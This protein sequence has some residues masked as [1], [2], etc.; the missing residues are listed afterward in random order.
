MLVRSDGATSG[1]LSMISTWWFVAIVPVCLALG[2][3]MV[4][5]FVS[6]QDRDLRRR[7]EFAERRANARVELAFHDAL[8][9]ACREAIR[10]E[11]SGYKA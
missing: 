11:S 4:A 2:G 7:A 5:V 3:L 10:A 1:Y 8:V 6:L 9:K